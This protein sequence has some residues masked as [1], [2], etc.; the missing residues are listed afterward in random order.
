MSSFKLAMYPRLLFTSTTDMLRQSVL[1]SL[2]IS[3]VRLP[4]PV[5]LKLIHSY[6]KSLTMTLEV[7]V[8]GIENKMKRKKRGVITF[9][10]RTLHLV[11]L[12]LYHASVS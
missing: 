5:K 8:I 3:I 4:G 9:F 12:G 11:Q 2:E 7:A 10:M 1:L 6:P